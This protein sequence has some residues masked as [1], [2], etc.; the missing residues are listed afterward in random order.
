[1]FFSPHCFLSYRRIYW[2]MISGLP[3]QIDSLQRKNTCRLLKSVLFFSHSL[4]LVGEG[5]GGLFRAV[6]VFRDPDR[7][8][9]NSCNPHITAQQQWTHNQQYSSSTSSFLLPVPFPFTSVSLRLLPLCL[10][11]SQARSPLS[12]SPLSCSSPPSRPLSLSF[13]FSLCLGFSVATALHFAVLEAASS[14]WCWAK[15][16]CWPLWLSITRVGA[17]IGAGCKLNS[18]LGVWRLSWSV[19][20]CHFSKHGHW[21]MDT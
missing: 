18:E 21:C 13:S 12:S 10:N 1:M 8:C 9:D 15:T 3:G 4:L 2:R 20:T 19:Y 16:T 11:G 6:D 17:S 5:S 14:L 7:K